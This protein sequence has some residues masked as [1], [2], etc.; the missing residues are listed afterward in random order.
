MSEEYNPDINI[1]NNEVN[2]SEDT[3]ESTVNPT[4]D[5]AYSTTGETETQAETTQDTVSANSTD[6]AQTSTA[7]TTGTQQTEAAAD[8]YSKYNFYQG[9]PIGQ[10]Y[11]YGAPFA[12]GTPVNPNYYQGYANQAQPG[13]NYQ[14][15]GYGNTY[16]N[17]GYITRVR[18]ALRAIAPLLRS[19]TAHTSH[20]VTP[21]LTIQVRA[22]A[23]SR[24][25]NTGQILTP[26]VR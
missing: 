25:L 3:P 5:G 26:Q 8:P 12:Q 6:T 7:D 20:Q 16:A 13:Q 11:Q 9:G 4:V 17:T 21:E 14:N 23:A 18:Q 24:I 1:E 2:K 19:I 15:P 10:G 22:T